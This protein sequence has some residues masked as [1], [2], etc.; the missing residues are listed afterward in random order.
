MSRNTSHGH[1]RKDSWR[2]SCLWYPNVPPEGTLFNG[3]KGDQPPNGR[4]IFPTATLFFG[5]VDGQHGSTLV[6]IAIWTTGIYN[7]AGI[8]FLYNDASQNRHLGHIGPFSD[9]HPAAGRIKVSESRRTSLHIDGLRGEE[10]QSI[11]VQERGCLV[12]LKVGQTPCTPNKPFV[13]RCSCHI[14]THE[15]WSGS[16]FSSMFFYKE[17]RV[18]R[19]VDC[20]HASR[21]KGCWS[22]W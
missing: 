4:V 10:L 7:I 15:L 1:S 9:D 16:H 5:G 12:G 14:D 19:R 2:T 13:D 3:S 20:Y 21:F 6:E 17:G 11:E 8:E 22:V 18:E